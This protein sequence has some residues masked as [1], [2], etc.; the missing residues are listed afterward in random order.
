M[1]SGVSTPNF[2]VA[3]R[4]P[5]VIR[6][7]DHLGGKR[8]NNIVEALDIFPTIRSL[9]NLTNVNVSHKLEGKNLQRYLGYNV[10]NDD[11]WDPDNIAI[12]Q[13]IRNGGNVIGYSLK[14]SR[15]KYTRWYN[16]VTNDIQNLKY[17]VND[18]DK[19]QYQELYD[20][21]KDPGEKLQCGR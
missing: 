3:T 6:L 2:D 1:D 15:F 21:Y 7:P 5:L 8:I 11:V 20:T 10:L 19:F 16:D 17:F 18:F 14:N 4:I 9:C 12:I 13:Y